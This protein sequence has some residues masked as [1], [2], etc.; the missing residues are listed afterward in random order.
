MPLILAMYTGKYIF[1]FDPAILLGACAGARTTTAALGMVRT[2]PRARY[3]RSA[4]P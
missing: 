3:R 4:T 1:K 2:R